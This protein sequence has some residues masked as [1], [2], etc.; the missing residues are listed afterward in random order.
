MESGQLVGIGRIQ[1]H[2]CRHQF[3]GIVRLQESRAIGDDGVGG[4]VGLVEPVTGK[5]GDQFENV[6]GLGA[7]DALLL[8]AIQETNL[9]FVHFLLF[10]LAH[11]AAQKVGFTQRIPRQDL[12]DLH[13]LFLIDDDAIGFRQHVFQIRVQAIHFGAPEFPVDINVDVFHR[14]GAIE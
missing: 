14:A 1:R 6:G 12:G 7:I 3:D 2:Q 5:F 9:L 4:G 13:D 11:G 10:L 8:G